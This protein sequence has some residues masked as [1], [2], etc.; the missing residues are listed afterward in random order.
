MKKG[1][2]KALAAS[3][4]LLISGGAAQAADTLDTVYVDA[5]KDQATLPGEYVK[6][7]GSVGILGDKKVME[8]PFSVT[9]VSQKTLDLYLGPNEPLDKALVGV[10]SIRASGSVL[11]GDYSIRGFRT[12]GTSM[13]VNGVHGVMTQFNLPMYAMEGIDIV[14]GPNSMLG[15]SGVQYES[16]TAGGIINA[17][18]KRA[19][20]T[21]FI[22]YKQTFSGKGS[23]GEYLDVSQ[24]FGA[25]RSWGV[26]L[27]TEL[28]NGETAVDDANMKA[29]GVAINIDHKDKHSSTNFFANYRDLDIYNGIRW[30]KLANPGT[31]TQV[32]MDGNK[33]SIPVPGVTH[34]PS[35]PDG[36]KNYSADGTWKA[37]Y[38]WFMT[39]NHEQ[40]MSEDWTLFANFGYSRQ[41]LNQNVSPYM[42][43]YWITN[44]AGDYDYV[45]TNSA[46]PQRSYYAQFGTKNKFETGAVKHEVILSA[47]KAWRNRNGSST[48][49]GNRY[50]GGS[51]I[52]SHISNQLADAATIGYKTRP[53]NKTSIWGVSLLDS[54]SYGKWNAMIGI[55]KHEAKTKSWS[56]TSKSWGKTSKYDATCP[57]YSLSYAPNDQMLIYGNHSE[58][59]DM[60]TEAGTSYENAGEVL[61]PAK[62][63][64]NEIGIKYE[65]NGVLYTLAYFDIDQANN[66]SER[67]NGKNYLVQDGKVNHK[68]VELGVNGRLADKWYGMIGIA[69][70][71]ARYKNM[72]TSNAFKNGVRESG[73][74]LW[75]GSA[76]LEYKASDDFSVI[77][78][79]TYTGTTPFYTVDYA[80][81]N[82]TKNSKHLQA[83]AYMVYDLGFTYSTKINTTPVKFTAMCYN[84]FDKDYWTVARG[85]QVYLST[86]RTFFLSAEFTL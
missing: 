75:S 71:D 73:Q 72:G 42:S 6:A 86:P 24:R 40:Y 43:S 23:F 56:T 36:S 51:N 59:F 10:P 53:N 47:D 38:G 70:M 62:V 60:G 45:Q 27:N 26:R 20:E 22:K 48:V 9:N 66:V 5:N 4:L 55:H 54:L 52:Y 14:S 76:A 2:Y 41:K 44:D 12:N 35:A 63:K 11:H 77:A 29:K 81:S 84:L 67:I 78:R 3:V 7:E 33:V 58:N 1:I 19:G 85:D 69:Y 82:A 46:T 25:D 50:M 80:T 39:L 16:N 34:L 17:R 74:G 28:L 61:P 83:P 13:Y 15:A 68:G 37:G 18:T 31:N 30:F 8:T 49:P 21:D 64:Q 79:A 32:G 57:T 65:R